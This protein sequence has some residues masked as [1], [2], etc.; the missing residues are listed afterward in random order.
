M[1]DRRDAG[2]DSEMRQV[3]ER[4][5]GSSPDTVSAGALTLEVPPPEP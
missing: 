4:G 1:K 2:E 5:S 3:C